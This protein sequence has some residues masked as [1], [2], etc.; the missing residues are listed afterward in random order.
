[1]CIFYRDAF[2]L[3][4]VFPFF[5]FFV[6]SVVVF[7][8]F[9]SVPKKGK[10]FTFGAVRWQFSIL[11]NELMLSLIHTALI[12][13]SFNCFDCIYVL[14]IYWTLN[15]E[16]CHQLR[17]E[18]SAIFYHS[19]RLLLFFFLSRLQDLRKKKNSMS[20]F[21]FIAIFRWLSFVVSSAKFRIQFAIRF[22][23]CA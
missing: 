17:F 7:S 3:F 22:D 11:E 18:N 5:S 19:F 20:P 10:T 4:M 16:H 12:R 6:F 15:I 23:F 9:C 21:S 13:L 1:M 2:D 14:Y 8:S